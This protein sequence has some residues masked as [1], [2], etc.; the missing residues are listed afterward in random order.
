[1][2]NKT[3]V[4]VGASGGIGAALV[5]LY[6]KD[7]NNHVYALSRSGT[8]FPHDNVTN[9]QFDY[10][11]ESSIE[12]IAAKISKVGLIDILLVATGIL[13][14][15]QMSPEKSL[16]EIDSEKFQKS[17]LI[18]TIGPAL[19][20]KHFLPFFKKETLSVL[21]ILSARVGS[22][23]DNRLGGWYAYRASKAA[24]NMFIKTTS[25]ELSRRQKNVAIIGL[26]PG[27]VNTN[28]SKPF[29][30]NVPPKK[31]FSPE[32]SAMKLLQVVAQ[33]TQ[34]DNGKL[35]AWDGVEIPW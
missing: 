24:V 2:L 18:N 5:E 34:Q 30:K 29:Q 1:M 26:H 23:S 8:Q 21:G 14:D 20:A 10:A 33:I 28:L 7:E 17:F 16:R 13:H 19:V 25:I 12:T 6:A 4:I 31:L 27:T 35:M 22:I 32:L 11:Q 15:D 9:D 3:V